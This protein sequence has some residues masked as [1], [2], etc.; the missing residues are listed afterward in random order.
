MIPRREPDEPKRTA[1]FDKNGV[2]IKAGYVGGGQFLI[3]IK[4]NPEGRQVSKDDA[5]TAARGG[6]VS[7]PGEIL[8]GCGNPTWARLYLDFDAG[9]VVVNPDYSDRENAVQPARYRPAR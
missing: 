8:D 9:V 4:P 5:E 1:Q 2:P 3:K 6:T 7:I